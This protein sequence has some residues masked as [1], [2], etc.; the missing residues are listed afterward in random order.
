MRPRVI[1]V[2]L[3]ALALTAA[4]V[5]C[6]SS[7]KPA[8]PSNAAGCRETKAAAAFAD[9]IKMARPLVRR[10][11]AGLRAPGMSL[12]V[13]VRGKIVW[14]VDCGYAD[15]RARRPVNDHTRFRIGS[16]SKTLTAAALMHYVE[17]GT[18]DLDAPIDRYLASFP[19]HNG[20]IT[21]RRLAGHLAGIRHYET[22]AERLTGVTS[23]R[24]PPRWRSSA[25]TPWSRHQVRNSPTPV[26]A[27]TSSAPCSSSR[28]TTRSP[29]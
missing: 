2:V 1:A 29:T 7:T 3:A 21:L 5:A 13:V 18:V 4:N 9:P 27:T 25:T 20:G 15:V 14:S 8:R 24:S 23:R 16:V 28:R 12:A 10:L 19:S 6:G 11:H 26:T 17:T 22:Q